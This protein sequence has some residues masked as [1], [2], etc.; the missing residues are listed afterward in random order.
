MLSSSRTRGFNS[1]HQPTLHRVWAV[2]CQHRQEE[3]LESAVEGRK[4]EWL[5]EYLPS[6]LETDCPWSRCEPS[7]GLRQHR[8]GKRCHTHP[9]QAW[10]QAST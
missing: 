8:E 3:I 7:Q 9:H 2:H 1:A 4:A 6:E 10:P 5:A